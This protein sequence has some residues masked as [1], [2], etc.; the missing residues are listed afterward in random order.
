MLHHGVPALVTR[1]ID[2]ISIPRRRTAVYALLFDGARWHN[3]G[4]GCASPVGERGSPGAIL[5]TA[6]PPAL[7]AA[8][9]GFVGRVTAVITPA[10][11]LAAPLSVV[12]AGL[13]VS[14]LLR[15]IHLCVRGISFGP[16]GTVLTGTGLLAIARG[17]YVRDIVRSAALHADD[18]RR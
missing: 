3:L 9:R 4:R 7:R 8:L 18:A 15:G 14:S 5:V 12:T 10:N 6:G 1:P 13:L 16:V 17:L 11:R 2:A